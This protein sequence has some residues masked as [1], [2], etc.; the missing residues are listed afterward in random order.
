MSLRD[1][2]RQFVPEQFKHSDRLNGII[3]L[4]ADQGDTVMQMFDE[5]RSMLVLGGDSTAP[6]D[7]L[8]EY[9]GIEREAGESDAD[10]EAR[11][12]EGSMMRGVPTIEAVRENVKKY[13]GSSA[14]A[15]LPMWP[16]GCYIIPENYADGLEVY[17]KSLVQAGVEADIGT[18]LCDEEDVDLIVSDEETDMPIVIGYDP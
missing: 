3:G 15:I 14:C 7:V 6:L 9:L 2:V 12:S 1:Y 10:Y 11:M 17:V 13:T 18:Y 8:G 16:C 4:V 5:L